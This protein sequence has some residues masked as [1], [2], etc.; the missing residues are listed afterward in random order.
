MNNGSDQKS[1]NMAQKH[2]RRL[3]VNEEDE[4]RHM[5]YL[6]GPLG[7]IRTDLHGKLR[8]SMPFLYVTWKLKSSESIRKVACG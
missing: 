2:R 5:A 4:K 8:S 7:N 6:T 3:G 1:Q